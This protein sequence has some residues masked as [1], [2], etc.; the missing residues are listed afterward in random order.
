MDHVMLHIGRTILMY[1]IAAFAIRLMGK[2]EIG[3]LSVFD[4][5]ISIMLA[6]IA[7]FAIEDIKRPIYEG[8]VP[9]IVLVVL[10]VGIALIGLKSR[11]F[12]LAL[13]GKPVILVSNGELQR[14]EMRKQRYNLDDLMQQLREQSIDNVD[15]LQFAILETT[16]K[17]TTFKKENNAPLSDNTGDSG[18]AETAH[19]SDLK[20]KEDIKSSD[21]SKE[22]IKAMQNIRYGALPL[23]LIMDGKV[24]DSNLELIEK[25]RFWLKN[26]I[27]EKGVKDFKDVFLCSIDHKGELYVNVKKKP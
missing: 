20:S 12:R 21:E 10:Q 15:D 7:V 9:I 24:Q 16:G 5:V 23:P 13:D 26:R 6:E 8:I 18:S 22:H 14:E 1:F 25:N 11:W 4:L 2:R 17:L 27:Q 19:E 3:K